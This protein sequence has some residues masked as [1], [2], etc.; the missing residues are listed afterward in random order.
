MVIKAII[1]DWGGVCCVAGEHF[2]NPRML[3]KAGLTPE[4]MSAKTH[5]I[6]HAFYR[7]EMTEQEFWNRVIDRY[8]L[9]G[10]PI[11]ELR[12]SYFASAPERAEIIAFIKR[13]RNRYKTALLSA[14]GADMSAHV[15]KRYGHL[16]DQLVFS[17]EIGIMKPD[18]RAFQHVLDRLGVKAE[19]CLFIDDSLKNV[20]AAARLGMQVVHFKNP[21]Q[22]L[23]EA[24]QKLGEL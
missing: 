12:A 10:I 2:S 19:D 3:A 8:Q 24:Q 4:E 18:P 13:T 1:W 15:K 23:A 22:T 17:H 21:E 7:G 11:E 14:L 20:E 9:N 16:F 5:D 6:E